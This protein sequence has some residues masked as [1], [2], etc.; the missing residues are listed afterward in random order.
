VS[1]R[2]GLDYVT[3]RRYSDEDRNYPAL[4]WGLK[5]TYAPWP[6]LELFHDHDGLRNLRENGV[7][8]HSKTGL[9]VPFTTALSAVAQVNVD[10][11]SRPAPGRESTDST[12]L[13]GLNYAW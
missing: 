1:L 13:M 5:A 9:R 12:V 6:A 4:G 7:V 10:W 11:E 8:V 2:G 3:E